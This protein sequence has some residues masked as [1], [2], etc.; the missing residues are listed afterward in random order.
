ML[1]VIT[2]G[3][4]PDAAVM[5]AMFKARKAVFVDLLGWDVPV[6]DG[7]YEIDQFDNEHARYL[8]VCDEDE[9]LA[10]ARLLPTTREG[11]LSGLFPMLCDQAPPSAPG[12]F[13]ITR[14]CLDRRLKARERRAARDALLTAIADYALETGI[15]SYC[16]VAE[17]GWQR[18]IANFGWKCSA[19]GAPRRLDSGELIALSIEIEADTPARLAAAGILAKPDHAANGRFAA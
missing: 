17:I 8:I 15:T 5:R 2:S 10:S 7:Q 3:T 4:E 14:F 12:I 13:E 6:L 1:N 16:A 9:H 18:Q 11:I 19:L